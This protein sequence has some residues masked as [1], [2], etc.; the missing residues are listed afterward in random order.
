MDRAA[1]PTAVLWES[2]RSCSSSKQA[3]WQIHGLC[4]VLLMSNVCRT[5]MEPWYLRRHRRRQIH[6]HAVSSSTPLFSLL[7]ILRPLCKLRYSMI[8]KELEWTQTE[9][10]HA[11]APPNCFLSRSLGRLELFFLPESVSQSVSQSRMTCAFL[12]PNRNKRCKNRQTNNVCLFPS[13]LLLFF[14]V[15][16]QWWDHLLRISISSWASVV[17]MGASVML[18]EKR[19]NLIVTP[20]LQLPAGYK[21]VWNSMEVKLFSNHK[22]SKSVGGL[23]TRLCYWTDR[24]MNELPSRHPN[25]NKTRVVIIS[26]FLSS[27][28]NQE[29][30]CKYFFSIPFL[31]FLQAHT[32]AAPVAASKQASSTQVTGIYEGQKEQEQASSEGPFYTTSQGQLF[33]PK[34]RIPIGAKLQ[35][36]PQRLHT[37]LGQG[38]NRKN[39]FQSAPSY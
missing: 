31:K 38:W 18:Q 39:P 1:S 13:L 28:W 27:S 29:L 23:V 7:L 24:C 21:H 16:L 20:F 30:K 12:Y 2:Q 33:N 4:I 32:L 14:L 37:S 19:K 15:L 25:S 8:R 9:A 35:I 36:R 10:P 5:S 26:A 34:S 6:A 22:K 17:L 11:E 3:P